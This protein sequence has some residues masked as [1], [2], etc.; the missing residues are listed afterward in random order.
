MD[1]MIRTIRT[2]TLLKSGNNILHNRFILY[3]ILMVSILNLIGF[4]T[5]GN[6]LS[7]VI[8]VLVGFLTTFFSKNML[9]VLMVPLLITN[10]LNYSDSNME[11]MDNEDEKE[12]TPPSDEE[13]NEMKEKYSELFELQN[14][15]LDGMDKVTQSLDKAEPILNKLKEKFQS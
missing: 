7:P 8:F 12:E 13:I 11:G 1:K 2:S 10:I 9:V 5:N 3:F 4:A 6:L 15:I 14:T